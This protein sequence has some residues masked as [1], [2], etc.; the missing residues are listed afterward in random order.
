MSTT[1]PRRLQAPGVPPWRSEWLTTHYLAR[2]L[3]DATQ[4]ALASL[5]GTGREG[6]LA[7]DLGCGQRPWAA[8][9]GSVHCIGVD[10]STQD[11]RPDVVAAAASLPFADGRFDLVFSSQVL[12]HVPDAARAMT[13]CARVLRPGGELVLSVPFY[14]PLHEEPHDYRRFTPHG[15]RRVLSQAGFEA[16]AVR[17]DCGSLA[18]VAAAAL[19]LLPRR[20]GLW[21]AMAPLV[22]AVNGLVPLLQRFSRDRRSTLNWIVRARRCAQ[23]PA[24]AGGGTG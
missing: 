13:E 6:L 12:E 22:L 3:H 18:M 1:P 21:I 16:V 5:G 10:I 14:W 20:Q 8:L 24:V 17:G 11:A 15:L 9:L 23:V 19:E 2:G 7:L 4:G